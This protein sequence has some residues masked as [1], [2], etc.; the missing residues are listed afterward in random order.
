M[1]NQGDIVLVNTPFSDLNTL[2]KRPVLII[3]R[4]EYNGKQQDIIVVAITSN[5]IFKDYVVEFDNDDMEQGAILR[6][7]CVRADKIFSLDKS[8]IIKKFGSV[9]SDIVEKTIHMISAVIALP[10]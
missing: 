9:S 3:S 1:H 8:L 5:L 10:D 6:K 4:D 2:K 7:S